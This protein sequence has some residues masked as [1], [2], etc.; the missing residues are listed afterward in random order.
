[1]G[2]D[3]KSHRP[4]MVHRALFGSLERFFGILIEHHAGA[5]PV[6]LAPVQVVV[7]PLTERH[8]RYAQEVADRLAAAGVRV[9]IDDR[10]EKVGYRIRQAEVT[11]VPYIVVVGDREAQEGQ[12]SVRERGRRERGAMPLDTLLDE[13]RGALHPPV[14]ERAR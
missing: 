2:E 11:K 3:G 9:Q 5:F 4:L 7:L 13:L 14:T 12:V 6:W 8:T 10:N 1:I